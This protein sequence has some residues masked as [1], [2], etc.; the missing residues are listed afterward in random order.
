MVGVEVSESEKHNSY[1]RQATSEK[2]HRPYLCVHHQLNSK[3]TLSTAVRWR[4]PYTTL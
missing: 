2:R 1:S 3:Y 4:Q